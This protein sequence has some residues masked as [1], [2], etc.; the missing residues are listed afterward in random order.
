MR[1]ITQIRQQPLLLHLIELTRELYR[2]T[3]DDERLSEVLEEKGLTA[4]TRSL[5]Q[6]LSEQTGLDEGYMPLTPIDNKLTR[7]IRQQ[8]TNH[9][10]I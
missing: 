2:D 4:F 6:V 7:Q 10:K 8:L 3:V 1:I 5:M 9:L